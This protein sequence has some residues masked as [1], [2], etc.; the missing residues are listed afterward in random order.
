MG[1]DAGPRLRTVVCGTKFGRVYLAALRRPDS[2]CQLAG[3]LAQGSP[4]SVA[5][6]ADA[7]VP[8]FTAVEQIPADVDLA[9]VV[10]SAGVNGGPGTRLALELMQ[11]G[12]HVLQEHP[13][14]HDELAECIR[15]ARGHGV[16]H[17]VNTHYPH[18]EPVAR[19]IRAART[20]LAHQ[21]P[22]LVDGACAIQLKYSFFDIVGRALGRLRPWAFPVLPP[23]P[24]GTGAEAGR[25]PVLRSLDGVVA[26]VPVTLRL[27]NQLHAT[28]PD[29]H[30][31]LFH[32]IV[33]GTEGGSL[34]L[35]DTHGPVLWSP[36]PHVPQEVQDGVDPAVSS[37]TALGLA[38][39]TVL[40]PPRAPTWRL[41]MSSVWPA[42]VHAA[43]VE[44]RRAVLAGDALS[45]RGQYQLTL[46]QLVQDVSAR[47]GPPEL[48]RHDPPVPLG[49]DALIPVPGAA[50]PSG[51]S[52]P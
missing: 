3:I 46:A 24:P 12:I 9:C 11:R 4:R 30:A 43:L 8:L 29:N 20:L 48:L 14:Y 41:I 36:R 7:G 25:V 33:I 22:L 31:H 52:W 27:Q 40:G 19:F 44:V 21:P 17:Y 2:P 6:A 38:S 18:V 28:D 10:V 16:V 32:R 5:S 26:G 37:V 23:P 15:T 49:V 1:G 50:Q 34:A 39:T 42:A 35:A 47:Y 13:L 51:P 45:A